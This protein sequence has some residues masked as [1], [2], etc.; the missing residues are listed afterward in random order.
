MP[1]VTRLGRAAGSKRLAEI[2]DDEAGRTER[3]DQ[4]FPSMQVFDGPLLAL[5]LVG[6]FRQRTFVVVLDGDHVSVASI[7]M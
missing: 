3:P 5:G 2:L 4:V 7:S 6:H 1:E